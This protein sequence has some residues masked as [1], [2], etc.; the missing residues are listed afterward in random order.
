MKGVGIDVCKDWLDVVV[1][2][3]PDAKRFAND[4]DGHGALVK[5]LKKWRRVRV[6]VEATGAYE[7]ALLDRLHE[8]G[9]WVCQ[10]NPRQA[11][12]FARALNQLAKT[13]KADAQVLA[14]MVVALGDQLRAYE[15]LEDW[16]AR[17]RAWVQ[18]RGHVVKQILQE[19]Q[20][21]RWVKEPALKAQMEA[22]IKTLSAHKRELERELRRQIK[23]RQSVALTTMKGLGHVVKATLLARLPELGKL[24]HKAVAKLVG[25]APLNDDSGN[26]RGY[27]RIGGGRADI[28]SVLYM[29]TLVAMRWEPLITTFYERLRA[30][31]KP[32]KVAMVA[33]MRKM[34]TILN[35]R[36]RDEHLAAA[37]ASAA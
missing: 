12:D 25:V 37:A 23:D 13:D 21:L 11:K 8:K 30:A 17:L 16:R 1:H 10:I 34:L 31:G 32:A 22:V 15:P 26:R 28:R 29:A 6:L 7:C 24:D 35:A 20:Q 33:C 19:K 14:Q 4:A 9:V 5:W 18:R 2:G 36:V 27:R 3:E